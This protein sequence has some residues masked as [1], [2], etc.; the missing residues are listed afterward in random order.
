MHPEISFLP[1]EMFYQSRLHDAPNL[2]WKCSAAW[3]ESNL[4]PPLSFYNV[5]GQE[6][7]VENSI[8]NR[9]ESEAAVNLMKNLL[10]GFPAS[11]A[12][13][14][15]GII[16]P[17]QAQLKLLKHSFRNEIPINI[18]DNIE[19]NTIVSPASND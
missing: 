13:F 9:E 5:E 10:T 14:K 16:T 3:H 6:R 15:I 19:F 17:Y 12:P 18:Y 2:E 11:R 4:F 1:R 8:L 7:E